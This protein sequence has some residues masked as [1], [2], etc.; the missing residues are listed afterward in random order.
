M[1]RSFKFLAVLLVFS[2]IIKIHFVVGNGEANMFCSPREKH[3]LLTFKQGLT[4]RSHRL[5]SWVGENCCTWEGVGCDSMTGSVVR[6]DLKNP[7]DDDFFASEY[8]AYLM[9]QLGGEINPSLLG[10]KH[11]KSLDLSLNDFNG[12][13]VGKPKGQIATWK[14]NT[15]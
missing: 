15:I 14:H 10:L 1:V 4:D 12:T 5:S 2:F 7:Y 11:L 9:A 13:S 3:A 6:L 8:E